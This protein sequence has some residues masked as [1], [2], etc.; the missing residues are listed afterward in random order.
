MECRQLLTDDERIRPRCAGLNDRQRR[1]AVLVLKGW[2]NKLIACEL[3]LSGS[4]VSKEIGRAAARLGLSRAALVQSLADP[5]HPPPQPLSS[6]T[7]A[8]HDVAFAV[9]RGLS[10]AEIAK[11]RGVSQRT[12][13]NQLATTFR[14]LRVSSRRELM[15]CVL[16]TT[17]DCLQ[18]RTVTPQRESIDYGSSGP[19]S[20]TVL[21]PEGN[22][23]DQ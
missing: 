23:D 19:V 9:A 15:V 2:S 6:L 5:H 3:G 13:A 14:K 16:G 10:N 1:I 17:R 22:R 20:S 21:L 11:E 8:Q 18:S 12:I 4:T 7:R